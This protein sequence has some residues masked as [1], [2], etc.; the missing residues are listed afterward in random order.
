MSNQANQESDSE[1]EAEPPLPPLAIRKKCEL[2]LIQKFDSTR[3]QLVDGRYQCW[4]I[5]DSKWLNAWSEFVN[6]PTPAEHDDDDD[7]DD[8]ANDDDDDDNSAVAVKRREKKKQREKEIAEA[9]D[10]PGKLTT[11]YLYNDDYSELLPGLKTRIDYRGVAPVVYYIFLEL[12]GKDDSP[13]ICRY[14]VDIYNAPVSVDKLVNIKLKAMNIARVET[15]K[16]RPRWINWEVQYDSDD[17]DDDDAENLLCCLFCGL[18]TKEHLEA[19]IYWSIT[20]WNSR[21]K[22]GRS[23]IKYSQ[24][25]PLKNVEGEGEDELEGESEVTR[26][27]SGSKLKH[28]K[29]GRNRLSVQ[30]E[31]SD[32]DTGPADR[33]YEKG[34]WMRRLFAFR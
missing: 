6:S 10:P 7:D 17:G 12:Y 11:H 29:N 5:I 24:Y 28:K 14:V 25:K 32:D 20:C 31:D 16:V 15:N 4:F 34:L 13:E 8:N 26:D 19:F 18:L 22:A 9:V 3:L 33:D 1:S 23:T 27:S 30:N 21:K 2:E